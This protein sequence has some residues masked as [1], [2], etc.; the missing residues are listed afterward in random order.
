MQ[1]IGTSENSPSAAQP[2]LPKCLLF[3]PPP[4]GSLSLSLTVHDCCTPSSTNLPL[5]LYSLSRG[6]HLLCRAEVSRQNSHVPL[7]QP[8]SP[9]TPVS[10]PALPAS[11]LLLQRRRSHG[12]PAFHHLCSGS[13]RLASGTSFPPSPR[14]SHLQQQPPKPS[15]SP[16]P[17]SATT[18]SLFSSQANFWKELAVLTLS[19][20]APPTSSSAPLQSG[21]LPHHS[22][23]TALLI[24]KCRDHFL[25]LKNISPPF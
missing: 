3:L 8:H 23:K 17:L 15:S 22:A 24:A 20:S 25:V 4:P 2:I 14:S 18:S 13:C 9:H 11:L 16:A 7:T 1:Q 10:V 5:R 21:L 6:L 19:A 12:R